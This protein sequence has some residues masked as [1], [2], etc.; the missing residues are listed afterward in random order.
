MCD[1]EL[2]VFQ[3]STCTRLRLLLTSLSALLL[4]ACA[5]APPSQRYE[6]AAGAGAQ[7]DSFIRSLRADKARNVQ[8]VAVT[9]CNVLFAQA[10]SASAQTSAGMF[11]HTRRAE[12]R[13]DQ[14]YT[15]SGLAPADMQR[16]ADRYCALAERQIAAAGYQVVPHEQLRRSAHYQRL[17][18]AG[19]ASPF[20]FSQGASAY[21][22]YTRQGETI[23]D[24]RYLNAFEGL[25]AAF[26]QASGDTPMFHEGLVLE[27]LGAS[28]VNV[29]LLIDFAQLASNQ[30]KGFLSSVG[31]QDVASVA[32]E[33]LLSASG[34]ISFLP[35]DE[36][37][38]W[39]RF[40]KHECHVAMRA[41]FSSASP[42]IV[43]ER[44][45]ENVENTTTTGDTAVAV[46]TKGLAL[47]GG[48]SSVNTTRYRVD[49]SPARFES[50]AAEAAKGFFD[51]ALAKSAS[52]RR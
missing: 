23:S 34:D 43:N 35:R 13:V 51:M 5:S 18:A 28:G 29:T 22:A 38:C 31:G 6:A 27:E 40:G 21:Q 37:K 8:R 33:V 36:L 19:K 39:D 42:V 7:A 25:G 20:G 1:P 4:A 2:P 11:S 50:V 44:F 47:F 17:M 9:S 12:A 48:G 32:G 30:R 3:M 15:L 52:A 14:V 49:V 16:M 24:L 45:Y 41:Q 26:K 46:L 10:S